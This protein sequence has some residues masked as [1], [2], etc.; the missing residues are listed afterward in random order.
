M[1]WN[2]VREQVVI[3][4]VFHDEFV[5][6]NLTLFEHLMTNYADLILI[7]CGLFVVIRSNS[8]ILCIFVV[9]RAKKKGDQ[10]A[11]LIPHKI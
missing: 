3:R 10:M 7:I 4:R 6:L 5:T 1:C 8:Y 2:L 11:A 9:F